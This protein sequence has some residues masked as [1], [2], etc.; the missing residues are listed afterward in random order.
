MHA[1]LLQALRKC[2][3][4]DVRSLPNFLLSTDELTGVEHARARHSTL[5]HQILDMVN[6]ART[7]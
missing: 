7:D 2:L 6:P 4:A 1:T 3:I 5:A